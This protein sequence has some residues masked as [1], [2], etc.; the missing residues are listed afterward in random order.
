MLIIFLKTSG[1]SLKHYWDDF[2]N[3]DFPRLQGGFIWDFVD[4]GIL[5]LEAKHPKAFGYGCEY[6]ILYTYTYILY[7]MYI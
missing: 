4:Q 6:Y 3:P 2:R 1:G 7:I 5:L